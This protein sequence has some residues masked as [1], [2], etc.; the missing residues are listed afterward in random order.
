MTGVVRPTTNCGT[1]AKK[2]QN[3]WT[4]KGEKN[5]G[6]SLLFLQGVPQPAPWPSMELVQ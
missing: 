5:F 6:F 4:K 1:K 2:D 3:W